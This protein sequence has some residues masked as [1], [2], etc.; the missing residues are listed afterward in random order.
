MNY[1]YG[2]LKGY[3]SDD[4]LTPTQPIDDFVAPP[5]SGDKKDEPV[6]PAPP[7]YQQR[8]DIEMAHAPEAKAIAEGKFR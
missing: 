1:L 4:D 3:D 5:Y 7:V 6:V 2:M 8:P